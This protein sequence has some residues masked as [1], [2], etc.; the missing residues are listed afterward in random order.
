[1]TSSLIRCRWL[2]TTSCLIDE[3]GSGRSE[4]LGGSLRRYR[5]K[6]GGG[7]RGLV[8]VAL[9]LGKINLL[10]AFATVACWLRPMR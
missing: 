10:G 7:C 3:R 6:H 9:G 5:R 8:R 1:M 4:K 2:G